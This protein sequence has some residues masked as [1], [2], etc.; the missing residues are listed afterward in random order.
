LKAV[1]VVYNNVPKW[2]QAWIHGGEIM[3]CTRM[4]ITLFIESGHRCIQ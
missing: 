3:M 1:I 2:I 4:Y